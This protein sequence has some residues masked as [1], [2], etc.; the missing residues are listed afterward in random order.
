[1]HTCLLAG[2]GA[3]LCNVLLPTSHADPASERASQWVSFSLSSLPE[4]RTSWNLSSPALSSTASSGRAEFQSS[5]SG[6]FVQAISCPCL[7]DR[8][9]HSLPVGVFF[10]AQDNNK[11]VSCAT[12]MALPG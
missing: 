3:A 10:L 6:T 11:V 1:M 7:A 4:R 8:A 9:S 2:N 5:H 12:G